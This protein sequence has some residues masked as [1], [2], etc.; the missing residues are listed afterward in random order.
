MN[1]YREQIQNL[2]LGI[3]NNYPEFAQ[4]AEAHFTYDFSATEWKE[5]KSKYTLENIAKNGTSFEKDS[6]GS[7]RNL[8]LL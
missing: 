8:Q 3:L 1:S 6:E 7:R 4:D 2:Y 5:L